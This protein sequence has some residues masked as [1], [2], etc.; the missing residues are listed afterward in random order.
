MPTAAILKQLAPG[1]EGEIGL[2]NTKFYHGKFQRLTDETI[3]IRLQ[4]GIPTSDR[5]NVFEVSV[6]SKPH[7]SRHAMI[8]AADGAGARFALGAYVNANPRAVFNLA[9]APNASDSVSTLC[10]RCMRPTP[11]IFTASRIG[12]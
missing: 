4:Y 3:I 7:R 8:G 11:S 5:Q 9:V 12:C 2:R 10:K 1:A 6:Q